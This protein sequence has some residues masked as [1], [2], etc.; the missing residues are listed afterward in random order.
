MRLYSLFLLAFVGVLALSG[1]KNSSSKKNPTTFDKP[2]TLPAAF[3]DSFGETW[4]CIN[5]DESKSVSGSVSFTR[6]IE[7]WNAD[8]LHISLLE[9]R[10]GGEVSLVATQCLNNIETQPVAY[11]L[12]Y[13]EE[14]IDP[15]A[16]YMLSTVFFTQFE[17]AYVASYRPDG[18]VEVIN[19]KVMANANI[20]LKV[21]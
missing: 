6:P 8:I 4:T 20:I 14:L 5:A 7:I 12:S 11:Q 16:R 19:N 3:E 1:C 9:M 17:G 2:A 21:P 15:N 18:F 10:D 13:N